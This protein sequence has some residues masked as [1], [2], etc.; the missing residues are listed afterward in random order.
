MSNNISKFA[1]PVFLRPVFRPT[2]EFIVVFAE[3]FRETPIKYK[4][5]YFLFENTKLKPVERFL[6][7]TVHTTPR[8][9]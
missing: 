1:R 4:T 5:G 7:S 2:P 3:N 9:V 8:P 6:A